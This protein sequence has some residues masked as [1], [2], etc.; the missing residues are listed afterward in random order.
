MANIKSAKKRN[1]T[2]EKARARNRATKSEINTFTKKYRAAVE[3]KEVE[4]A[5]ELYNKCAS[6][7][8]SAATNGVIH[9]NKAARCKARLAKMKPAA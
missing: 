7:L 5:T 6:L 9:T 2:N 1:K 8:D 3:A 4:L